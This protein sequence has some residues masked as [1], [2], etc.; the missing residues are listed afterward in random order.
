VIHLISFDLSL[1]SYYYIDFINNIYKSTYKH[2]NKKLNAIE[3]IYES[4]Y[5]ILYDLN[6]EIIIIRCISKKNAAKICTKMD[7]QNN[8]N[9]FK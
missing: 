7:A 2:K 1:K 6:R 5:R 4:I 9:K 3:S 8:A